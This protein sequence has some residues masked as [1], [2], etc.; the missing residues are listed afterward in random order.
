MLLSRLHC[1]L[2]LPT[3]CFLR[4]QLSHAFEVLCLFSGST[5]G[6]VI[7]CR[8]LVTCACP[9][10]HLALLDVPFVDSLLAGKTVNDLTEVVCYWV[11]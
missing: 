3:F 1:A 4:L 11:K 10:S 2:I 8:D 9:K 7:L 5:L 6:R